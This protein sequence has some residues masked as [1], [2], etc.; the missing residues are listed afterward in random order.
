[1]KKL[2]QDS[3]ID[4]LNML[5][6]LYVNKVFILKCSF[7]L[8]LIGVFFTLFLKNEYLSSSTFVPQINESSENSSISDLAS[9]AGIDINQ[10]TQSNSISPTLYPLIL[11]S[12]FYKREILKTKLTD[13]ITLKS[14]L[15]DYQK[16][17]YISNFL[18]F[19]KSIPSKIISIFT[20][21][22]S[23]ENNLLIN[24]D[25]IVSDEED[26]LFKMLDN[27]I[28]LDVKTREGFLILNVIFYDPVFSTIIL[29]NAK[30]ILEKKIIE[31]KIKSSQERLNYVQ[32]NFKQKEKEFEKIQNQLA[33]FK[34]QNQIISSSTFS[35]ELFKIQNKFDLINAVYQNLAQQVEEAK[36]QVSKDTPIFV[37]LKEPSVPILKF[38]PKRTN[39]AIM[40]FLLGFIS[41]LLII[42]YKNRNQ[43]IK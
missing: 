33:K 41:A 32:K 27:L 13:E 10:K 29:D 9:L 25:F 8:T 21:V 20:G 17:Q 4:I 2:D 24:P 37:T 39:L 43:I 34:D 22:I 16:K 38:Y 15:I 18:S 11:Q 7:L 30:K 26:K 6:I 1:M 19:I 12:T 40:S 23:N 36:I 31:V 5:K 14:Y 35:N 3:F 42:L 28:S